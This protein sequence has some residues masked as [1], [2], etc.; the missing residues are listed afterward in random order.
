MA[1]KYPTYNI[2][3]LLFKDDAFYKTLPPVHTIVFD[4]GSTSTVYQRETLYS[5]WF[6]EIF[7][8]YEQTV[9]T[10]KH[11]VH[12]VLKGKPL[13]S[14]THNALCSNILKSIVTSYGDIRPAFK[15]P[16]L[17]AIYKAISDSQKRLI[18]ETKETPIGIDI[19]DFIQIANH[20][21]VR[22]FK[23][24][25]FLDPDKIKYAYE[26]IS[27]LIQTLPDFD[28][29]GL[30][31][32]VRAGMVRDN[33]V[34]QCVAFRGFAT[35]VDGTVYPKPIWSNYVSGNRALADFAMDS[36]T[37]AKSH[38]YSDAS[39]KDSEYRAR[40]FQLYGC[41][42]QNIVYEDCG[43]DKLKPWFVKGEI[44]DATGTVTYGG[45][46]PMLIGKYYRLS[47]N[48][49]YSVIQGDE[50]HLVG[51]TIWMRTVLGC[52]AKDPHTACHIC[53]GEL[54]H[55]ISRFDN[56]GHLGIVTTTGQFT[57]NILSIKHVNMS[58]VIIKI[59]LGDFERKYLNVGENGD[60]FYLNH[61]EKFGKNTKLFVSVIRDEAPGLRDISEMDVTQQISLPRISQT[62]LIRL[63]YE[64]ADH[65]QI[66]VTVNVKV[67]K[68]PSMLSRDA[69][70]YIHDNGWS[71]DDNNNF[72]LDM[73][74]WDF[75]KPF[76][77]LQNKEVSFVDL[78]NEVRS[79]IQSSQKVFK[80]RA[81]ENAPFVLLQ[82]LFD[83]VNSKLKINILSFE[84]IIY[85]LIVESS[86]S[87]AMGRHSEDQT[88]G[89]ADT[90]VTY[91]SL[92]PAMAFE[93]H[94]KALFSPLYHAKGKRP[95]SLMDSFL[96]P[97][98]VVEAWKKKSVHS[99]RLLS[100]EI[101][102]V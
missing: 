13:G 76:L 35:E 6:W 22:S 18:V 34:L 25:A 68:A 20:P 37:A 39:L 24:K 49:P 54:H 12:S 10:N 67:K 100:D 50:T 88:L 57:Q 84:A 66:D 36:R 59:L 65:H 62:T 40:I 43:S 89:I 11:H 16:I 52:K 1:N 47:P 30:A 61:P 78:A 53:A 60:G 101:E 97:Q 28:D 33:Q 73:S 64:G 9:I 82:E 94:N 99:L 81:K 70:D 96:N 15:E 5:S 38:F 77:V 90:L 45:D 98:E 93:A 102:Q 3:E 26:G 85:G 95:D 63:V 44:K 72:V 80:N 56:L 42:L 46:L 31:K 48:D 74:K 19:L 51:Q 58:S 86:T 87:I 14:G 79:M 8:G 32:A 91:R 7:R 21:A 29:N 92:G 17:K 2:R 69:I 71:V 4:D 75:S 83:L 55:N 27:K 23:E 41:V